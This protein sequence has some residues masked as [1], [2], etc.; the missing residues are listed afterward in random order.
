MTE[1]IS[2]FRMQKAL[3]RGFIPQDATEHEIA[4]GL[5]EMHGAPLNSLGQYA[6]GET[7]DVVIQAS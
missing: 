7:V 3:E 4:V 6:L 2:D 5:E 1:N